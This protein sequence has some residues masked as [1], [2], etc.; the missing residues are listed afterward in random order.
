MNNLK[1]DQP[2]YSKKKIDTHFLLVCFLLLNRLYN[3]KNSLTRLQIRLQLPLFF[4][5]II[6]YNY[7][8]RELIDYYQSIT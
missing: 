6:D 8:N 5:N 4:L 2:L 7:V 1:L 3:R